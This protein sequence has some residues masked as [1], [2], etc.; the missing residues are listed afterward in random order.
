MIRKIKIKLIIRVTKI[1]LRPRNWL[2][3][4]IVK[5][6]LVKILNY[7]VTATGTAA[8]AASDDTTVQVVSAA[9]ALGP[10]LYALWTAIQKALGK[11]TESS[12]T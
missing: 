12:D 3:R 10:A 11:S 2:E 8:A 7:A 4:K 9:A 1:W 5:A 6:L